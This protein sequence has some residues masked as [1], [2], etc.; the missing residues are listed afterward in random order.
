[1]AHGQGKKRQL[2]GR[3]PKRFAHF[4]SS[5]RAPGSCE[6][7]VKNGSL[8]VGNGAAEVHAETFSSEY[9]ADNKGT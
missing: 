9:V 4:Q 1:M 2:C 8:G 7:V 6:S 5:W 3:S